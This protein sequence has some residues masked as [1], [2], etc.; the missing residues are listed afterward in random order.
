[1]PDTL[2][3]IDPYT[4]LFAVY[5]YDGVYVT[6]QALDGN[7]TPDWTKV[8]SG[9]FGVNAIE[10]SL[11]GNHMY[12]ASGS[13]NVTR[14]SG[15][16]DFWGDEDVSELTE[17]RIF[18]TNGTVT[19]IGVDP[20]NANRIAVAV[21]GYGGSGKV[22][23]TDVA[24]TATQTNNTEFFDNIWFSSGQDFAGMPCY[25]VIITDNQATGDDVIMVA[26][27]FGVW[28][29]NDLSDNNS[30]EQCS[31]NLG[32]VPVFDIK[33]QYRGPQ[34]FI[35]NP[36]NTGFV[37]IGTHGMGIWRSGGVVNIEEL[38]GTGIT[39]DDRELLIFPNPASDLV[40]LEVNL[41][42]GKKLSLDIYNIS[43]QLVFTEDLG[44]V[45]NG[46]QIAT[47][48]IGSL[49]SGNYIMNVRGEGYS[50]TG[51]LLVK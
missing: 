5:A 41:I 44:F 43:G 47:V 51:K 16:H 42:E 29:T 48:Y 50:E 25:D 3:I 6:R 23:I 46:S 21:G 36:T 49:N 12:L 37:Y 14:V 4:S 34:Q 10:F 24:T 9:N 1:V 13:G 26:T 15:F 7:T 31:N 38:P 40:N 30:W 39:S 8:V 20:N 11:D 18:R 22:W 17:T 33:Q 45:S 2:E 27:E 19:G 28:A 35:E 32:N